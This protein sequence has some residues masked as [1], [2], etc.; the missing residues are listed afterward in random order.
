[1]NILERAQASWDSRALNQI[2][3][4]E[5][6]ETD[7]PLMV[8]FRT[9][10]AATLSKVLRDSKG[11]QIEQAVYAVI[12]CATDKEGNKLFKSADF[13]TLM[14]KVDYSVVNRIAEAIMK[15]AK[16]DVAQAEKNSEAIQSG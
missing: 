8:Y 6:G 15:A 4:P 5:W 11:G 13:T 16:L 12:Y 14:H 1:M 3:V 10:S 9:P 7:V 2:E